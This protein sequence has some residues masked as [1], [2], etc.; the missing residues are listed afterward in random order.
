MHFFQGLSLVVVILAFLGAAALVWFAG[1][2]LS[3]TADDL[4]EQ[5]GIGRAF[6]GILLLGGIT[7]LPELVTTI[8]ASIRNQPAIAASN[9]IGGISMQVTLLSLADL[10]VRK[11]SITSA[12]KSVPVVFQGMF[13]IV[14]LAMVIF[15][16]TMPGV[17]I[18]GTG[19]WGIALFL[20]FLVAIWLSR[21]LQNQELWTDNRHAQESVGGQEKMSVKD[22][23]FSRRGLK[24]VGY[25]VLI[26]V[27][28]YFVVTSAE[29]IAERTGLGANA[30]G[31]ILIALTT[32]LPE[33]STVIGSAR[34]GRYE[35]VF[36]NIFGTN[37]FDVAL[38]FP[39]DIFYRRGLLFE[40]VGSFVV[41]GSA[42][43]IALTAV[44]LSGIVVRN[45]HHFWRMGPDSILGIII[46]IVG[47][48]LLFSMK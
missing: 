31:F 17:A 38:L 24:L 25:S 7:S 22:F 12:A 32:S 41:A 9:I 10:F 28:G 15:A 13:C 8:T 40:E 1:S 3:E 6:V 36:A 27:A 21:G 16:T 19:I 46:Y 45:K 4:S 35:L 37:L 26:V 11:G 44:F 5:T 48:I 34:L 18:L 29:T 30:T 42:L 14:M 33:I 20:T 2:R 39:A 43:A 47:V 23:I